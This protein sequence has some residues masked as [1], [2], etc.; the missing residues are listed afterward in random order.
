MFNLKFASSVALWI[1]ASSFVNSAISL[2]AE[3]PKQPDPSNSQKTQ[4]VVY[5]NKKYGFRFSLPENWRGYSISIAKWEGG[6]GESYQPGEAM[7]PPVEG[8]SIYIGHPL[9]TESN[10]R[11]GIPIMV[12]TK[13]QWKLVEEGKLILSAAPVG[14]SEL[15]RNRKYVFAMPAR[16][17]C[18]D[19][20]GQEEVGEILQGHP[21]HPF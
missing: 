21:L 15:G 19:V 5:T 18:A 4:S 1:V 7:P 20:E 11:Q 16:F 3:C 9:S 14:P 10:P 2:S 6:D 8:P 17:N 13:A 12:F